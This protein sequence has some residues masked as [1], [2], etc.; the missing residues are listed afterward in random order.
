MQQTIL[1]AVLAVTLGI[2]SGFPVFTCDK[3]EGVKEGVDNHDQY[4]VKLKDTGNY[5]DADYVI[6][7]VKQYQTSLES[8]AS[9][10]NEPSVKSELELS[11]TTGIL[12]GTLTK[13]ALIMV[14]ICHLL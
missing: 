1:V 11:E 13:Q 5:K 14:S 2:V 6:N 3:L 12:Q 4:L 8:Y 9:N 10:V 7:R